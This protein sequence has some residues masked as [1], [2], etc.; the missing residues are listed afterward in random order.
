MDTAAII[1]NDRTYIP[2]RAVF[3]AFGYNIEWH[4]NSSTAFYQMI[5]ESIRWRKEEY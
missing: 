3:G 4:N 1:K 2:L 5:N